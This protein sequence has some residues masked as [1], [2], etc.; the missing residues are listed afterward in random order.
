M[1]KG[2]T[3]GGLSPINWKVVSS[4]GAAWG[5]KKTCRKKG[6]FISTSILPLSVCPLKEVIQETTEG[7]EMLPYS[8][9]LGAVEEV[10]ISATSHRFTG[11]GT[12]LLE[13]VGFRSFISTIKCRSKSSLF[14]PSQ[15]SQRGWWQQDICNMNVREY[16]SWLKRD[17][18][19]HLLCLFISF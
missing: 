5:N 3:I 10:L 6:W 9:L 2:S 12:D 7:P 16:K 13:N 18:S 15:K 19:P 4:L 1:T 11:E 17:A 8:R 14:Q